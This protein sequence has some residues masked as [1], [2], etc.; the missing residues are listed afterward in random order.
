MPVSNLNGKMSVSETIPGAWITV[1]L[2]CVV[3]CLNYL[4]RIMITTMRDPITGSIPMTDAQFGLLT[5]SF[6]WAYGLSSPFAGF[7]ADRYKRHVVI[8][9]CLAAWS[10]VTW[11][12]AYA[13]TFESLLVTRVLMGLSEAC[14]IPAALALISDYHPGPTRSFA[15]GLHM[16]GIMAGQG[17]SFTGGWIAEK[18]DWG[19]AFQ[20]FGVIGIVYALL[21]LPLLR[22]APAGIHQQQARDTPSGVITFGSAVS[23]LA[24]NTSF[25]MLLCFWGILGLSWVV[26]GWLPSFY[27]EK[28][29]LPASRAGIY[30]TAYLNTAT[31]IGVLTGGLL[32]D[33]FSRFNSRARILVPFAGLCIA[34][35]AIFLAG[36]TAMLPLAIGGFMTYAFMLTFNDSN[37][38]PILG[39]VLDPRYRATGY[40]ILN[41][42]SCMVGGLGVYV[43][44][45]LLDV[46]V[47]F[48]TIFQLVALIIGGN[49]ILLFFI[50]PI[51]FK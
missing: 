18:H 48:D 5:S 24:K 23:H 44:G 43:S 20:V 38:M 33:Y 35:P 11:G 17:L 10:I 42:L 30:A 3:G 6:L 36:S 26:V 46:R 15:T 19:F 31:F 2:L 29:G 34:A 1:G 4:V 22:G 41:M 13:T 49:A 27:S 45:A 9:A 16:A 51:R 12:T 39:M 28:F 7:L 21:L 37:M 8:L 40:G 14:Y 47:S 25:L 50:K 32:A